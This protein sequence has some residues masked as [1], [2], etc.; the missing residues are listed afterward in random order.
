V[1]ER[2]GWDEWFLRGA[3]WAS[4]RGACSRRQVGALIIDPVSHDII[5]PGYNGPPSGHPDCL[6]GACPRGR[7]FPHVVTVVTGVALG[8]ADYGVHD[9]TVC[10]WDGKPWPCPDTVEPGSSYDT[11]PGRCIAI[12]AELNAIIRAGRRARGAWMYLT[13]EPCDGCMKAIMGSGIVR[14][15][16]KHDNPKGYAEWTAPSS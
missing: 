9:E 15:M 14:V 10:G 8:A 7:H 13:H 1:T 3:E 4:Q 11:G 6:Q 2:P 16:W 12:H 5:E